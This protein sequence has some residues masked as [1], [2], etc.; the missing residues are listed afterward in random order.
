MNKLNKLRPSPTK[1]ATLY[2]TGTI[3]T[4]NDGNKWIVTENKNKTKRWQLH[5]KPSK[6][7]TK[8]LSKVPSK[9]DIIAKQISESILQYKKFVGKS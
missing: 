9:K 8:K 1:S 4:G 3:K 6:I 5:R 2:K 7:P